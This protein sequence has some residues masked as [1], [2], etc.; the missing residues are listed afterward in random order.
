VRCS[1]DLSKLERP[2]KEAVRSVDPALPIFHLQPMDAYVFQSLAQRTFILSLI[3][4]FGVLALTLATVGVYGVV[5]YAVA[6]RSR[7]VGIRMALGAQR[8]DVVRMILYQV[9]VTA[10]IGLG[11]GLFIWSACSGL[12]NGL[13]FGVSPNDVTSV[14]TVAG[15]I[16]AAALLAGYLPARRAAKAIIFM[17]V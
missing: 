10:L 6:A 4:V 3:G 16:M 7:E 11:I 2:V 13:L 5:S 9:G 15:L 1:L 14:A 17:N 12:L 8:S